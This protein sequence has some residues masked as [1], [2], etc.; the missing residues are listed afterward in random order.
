MMMKE[1]FDM[2]EFPHERVPDSERQPPRTMFMVSL[3]L[4]AVAVNMIVGGTLGLAMPPTQWFSA[5]IVGGAILATIAGYTAWYSYKS[6]LTFA[7]Q[8]HEIFGLRG[9]RV[10]STFVGLI[11]LGWYTIQSSLLGHAVA[12]NLGLP[13]VTEWALLFIVPIVLSVSAIA[14]FRGLTI[15]SWIAVPA[16]FILSAIAIFTAP[17]G[18]PRPPSGA[19]GWN[20]ALTIVIG[21]WIMGAVATIG[22]I[23]RYASSGRSAV[24]SAVL[25][26]LIGDT[27][28][29]IAGA[30]CAANYGFGDLSELLRL[31]GLPT[32]AFIL[33]IF[34]I[35]STNDNSIYSV[36]LNWSHSVRMS[37]RPLVACAALLSA[38]ISL[39]R[40]YESDI[41][42]Q[43]LTL[44]GAVV[45]PVGGTIIGYR[46][47]NGKRMP[48]IISWIAIGVGIIISVINPLDLAPIWGFTLS[49]LT[50]R[51][52]GPIIAAPSSRRE[53]KT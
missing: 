22:D 32:L 6:G 28:L 15:L 53:A 42:A 43:W 47:T 46:L 24:I 25:A 9:S 51:V 37:F 12:V 1:G 27:A 44:L 17:P 29:M 41:V 34:N 38:V 21:L 5:I 23:A 13:P 3:G 33:L 2:Y 18:A 11:I 10:I 50:V 7:L 48:K 40:P 49:A 16:I 26:F 20:Q 45:P 30:W 8:T 31:S 35:W 36:G 19:I 52:I 39:F 14:G 4:T